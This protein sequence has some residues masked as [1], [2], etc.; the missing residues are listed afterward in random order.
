MGY[1][2]L[3]DGYTFLLE[4][5]ACLL[6]ECTS[7]AIDM[8]LV[9]TSHKRNTHASKRE[10]FHS[11]WYQMQETCVSFMCYAAHLHEHGSF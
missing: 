10:A 1:G 2:S 9:P 4:W 8:G 5:Y 6:D 11:I 3:L 7:L